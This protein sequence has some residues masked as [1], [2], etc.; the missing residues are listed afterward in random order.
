[1]AVPQIIEAFAHR[2]MYSIAKDRHT[3]TDF[4]VYQGLAFAVR[5]RLMERWFKTQSTYYLQDAKRV[6]YLSLEFLMGRALLNNVLNLGAEDSYLQAMRE[7]GFKLEDIG[8]Q[9]WDAGL[10]NGG[11]GRLAAC[12]LDAAATLEL[13]FYGYGI[14][15]EY[16]I[17]QQRILDGQQVEYPDGWLRYGNPWEIQRPDA[18]FPVRFYGHTRG[19]FDATG[20]YHVDWLDTQDVWAM[21]YDT[22]V[23]GFRNGTVNTLR[24]WSAKSSREF[25][26]AHFNSG[27]YVRAVEDKTHSENIS[28]VLY[29][30][31]DQSAGKELRLKQQ[32]FFVSA[33]LQD[34]VRRFK[35]RPSWRWEELP[36]KVAIQ[37]NDTHPALVVPELM[38]VLLDQ[39]GLEWDLAWSLTQQVCAYTNHTILPEAMEVWPMDLWRNLLPRHVEIVEEI[40]RRFRL[41]VR[42]R[43]PF[44]D[45]KLQRLAI[46]DHGHSVRMANLAIVGSHSVNGVAQLHTDILKASTFAEMNELF[47][48]RINNKTNGITPRRWLLKSNPDLAALVSEAIGDRWTKDLDA[49]RGLEPFATDAAFQERWTRVKRR[50]KERLADWGRRTQEFALDPAFLFDVQV[51]RIHEYKRQL[52]NLLHVA[53]LWNRLRDGVDG[54]VPRAVL[55]GGK[56][57]PAYWAAKQIIHLAN[58]M[59]RAIGEDPAAKGRLSLAFLPNYRVSLAEVVFPATELSEQISTAGTEASGTGNMKAALN[60]ALTIGTLD[61]A[62]VEIREEVGD[63][64]IFIFGH[65]AEGIVR[66]RDAGYKPRDWAM[67]HPELRRA[68]DTIGNLEGGRFRA[69]A[70]ALMDSDHYFHC[71]DYAS[72]LETQERVSAT[73]QKPAEWARMSILNVAGM[74]KFSIDRT[75]SEYARDIWNAHAVPV[76]GP[77]PEPSM[78]PAL[79]L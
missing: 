52:L 19:S 50:N 5:D 55:I 36:D 71:A 25:D 57:A 27:E 59:A 39:E 43:Y 12:I 42:A 74:G 14:R 35:K 72:Y 66:L 62:N 40:D 9:E 70:W 21:A 32:Y 7:L 30:A 53:T 23:A 13:P 48:G 51:K 38:R 44:D 67:A 15:Y 61:G 47:P 65:T 1:M 16:G 33:T 29:P 56:A 17:F 63:P 34:V 20:R 75:V 37:M 76:E 8:E 54:G 45:A 31:D 26:L 28:K 2:M 69:L 77:P 3:A 24:L 49:L 22:P 11:L 68:I 18:I 73:Y 4:D 58:A 79:R 64:N 46:V 41:A 6:Y 60:G 10:G 78:Q